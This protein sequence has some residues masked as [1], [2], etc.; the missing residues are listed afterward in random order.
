MHVFAHGVSDA[1]EI[2][3]SLMSLPLQCCTV[4]PLKVLRVPAYFSRERVF[5]SW[6]MYQ[7]LVT[8]REAICEELAVL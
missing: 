8:C 7:A 3:C 6:G 4:R 5:M 1:I 2:Q